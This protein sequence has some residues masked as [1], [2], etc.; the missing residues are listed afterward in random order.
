MGGGCERATGAE[1]DRSACRCTGNLKKNNL[2]SKQNNL[3]NLTL[4]VF[5]LIGGP[6]WVPLEDNA[7]ERTLQCL[8][9]YLPNINLLELQKQ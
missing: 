8:A 1:C 5:I 2:N 7:P 3:E 6:T 9:V 4:S